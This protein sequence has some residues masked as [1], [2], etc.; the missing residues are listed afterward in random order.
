MIPEKKMYQ[1]ICEEILEAGLR[2]R[3]Q[4]QIRKLSSKKLLNMTV[5]FL[6]NC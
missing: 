6:A 4:P 2:E 5:M 3:S 1:K